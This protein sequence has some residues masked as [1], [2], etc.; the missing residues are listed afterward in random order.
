MESE[1]K[2]CSAKL[3]GLGETLERERREFKELESA[4]EELE[5]IKKAWLP[6]WMSEQVEM[7]QPI[8]LEARPYAERAL[9]SATVMW[10][11]TVLPLTSKGKDMSTRGL[12]KMMYE[13]G[14]VWRK[15]VPGKY[16]QIVDAYIHKGQ[17]ALSFSL[18]AVMK[19]SRFLKSQL[20]I[21]V[22]EL[23]AMV[24]N[25]ADTYPEQFGWSK[26]YSVAIAV[27]IVCFPITFVAM[28]MLASRLQSRRARPSEKKRNS[29]KK[30]KSNT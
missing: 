10:R 4:M 20:T 19:Y 18:H 11:A 1:I 6:V 5:K 21:I 24:N 13:I 29:S 25:L 12:S 16:R 30:K 17:E 26:K 3:Q 8:L 22:D 9:T 2:S 28:P 7:M 23:S 27:F 15:Q 14:R